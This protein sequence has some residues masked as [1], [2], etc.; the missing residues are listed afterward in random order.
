MAAEAAANAVGAGLLLTAL[1]LGLRHG[2]DWDH[3]AAI[4]DV[5]STS[6][7]R[8]ES[9][10]LATLYAL[11][12]A[13]VVLVL[14]VLAI[15]LSA[16]VPAGLDA[17]MERVVGV[18]LVILGAWVVIGL[19]RHGRDFRLRSRWML[20]FDWLGDMRR[21]LT[22]SPTEPIEIDHDHEH[23]VAEVHAD[24]HAHARVAVSTGAPTDAAM[25]RHQ[26]RHVVVP[27][28]D[29]FAAPSS[30]A[31]FLIGML[32]GVGAETPT[33]VA[34][35]VAA[36]GV[37]GAGFGFAL[38]CAF[39]VGLLLSNTGIAL[40]AAQG[41]LDARRHFG[42]HATVS[43]LVAALSLALGVALLAGNGDVFPA[44]LS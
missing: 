27:P 12:H 6:R 23:P 9:M 37:G 34:L 11:G 43:V 32:H 10:R 24:T 28:R 2:V 14:G 39:I 44:L 38:L 22:S 26:H 19:V 16:V 3:I 35:F 8:R 41:F 7:S 33:Q 25:H 36:A 30:R 15:Q 17:V 4:T 40:I 5:A 21:R 29:P 13:L 18:T 42:V 20:L 1:G 31:G